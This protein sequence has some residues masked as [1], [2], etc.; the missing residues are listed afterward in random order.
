MPHRIVWTIS[1]VSGVDADHVL[2]MWLD[3]EVIIKRLRIPPHNFQ[4]SFP[5]R[6]IFTP[7]KTVWCNAPEGFTGFHEGWGHDTDP[8][9]GKRWYRISYHWQVLKD[10]R[11]DG[12]SPIELEVTTRQQGAW[13]ARSG[14]WDFVFQDFEISMDVDCELC[15]FMPKPTG[16]WARRWEK[17]FLQF[18][19]LGQPHV[20]EAERFPMLDRAD[21]PVK[22][23]TACSVKFH[24]SSARQLS[25]PSQLEATYSKGLIYQWLTSKRAGYVLLGIVAVI[26]TVLS[27]IL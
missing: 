27:I 10:M 24:F 6:Y 2:H 12:Q 25:S 5:S 19:V 8:N 4:V 7:F 20:I 23:E 16:R 15:V 21:K 11:W 17:V 18:S 3:P 14:R 13:L 9:I 1:P 22:D 26:V